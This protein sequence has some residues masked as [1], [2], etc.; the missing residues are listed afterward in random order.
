M[1]REARITDYEELGIAVS[2]RFRKQGIGTKL[3]SKAEEWAK[4][5]E[6]IF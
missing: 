4:S 3:L 1:I 6:I 2:N 5:R